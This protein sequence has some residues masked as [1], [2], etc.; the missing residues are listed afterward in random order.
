MEQRVDPDASSSSSGV[1]LLDT[2]GRLRG[3]GS[4]VQPV[5]TGLSRL[6]G[7]PGR[8]AVTRLRQR[9]EVA[10]RPQVTTQ[11]VSGSAQPGSHAP[12]GVQ[13]RVRSS[14]ALRP[15]LAPVCR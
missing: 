13:S 6:A 9:A 12:V 1:S 14:R 7:D 15:C 11:P 8:R 4:W 2:F 5:R 10:L 3:V